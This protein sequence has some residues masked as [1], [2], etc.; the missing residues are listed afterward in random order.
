MRWTFF[1]L[2][3]ACSSSAASHEMPDGGTSADAPDG[4]IGHADVALDCSAGVTLPARSLEWK[5]EQTVTV[6]NTG[7][8][9]AALTPG[10]FA[11]GGELAYKGGT[12]PGAGGTCGGE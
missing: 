1:V 10:T 5:A 11:S 12:F 2:L 8:G 4:F 6:A 9:A 7:D 3:A